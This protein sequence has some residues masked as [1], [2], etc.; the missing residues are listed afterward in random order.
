MQCIDFDLYYGQ[1]GRLSSFGGL[2]DQNSPVFVFHFLSF[3]NETKKSMLD[4]G[5]DN[6][7]KHYLLVKIW[8]LNR[9]LHLEYNSTILA[10]QK[11]AYIQREEIVFKEHFISLSIQYNFTSY[12]N[13]P[14][15]LIIIFSNVTFLL[16]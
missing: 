14:M 7:Q 16:F 8:L 6:F 5:L 1:T 10:L 9:Y 12:S 3:K 15:Y 2:S 4:L 11:C 13:I